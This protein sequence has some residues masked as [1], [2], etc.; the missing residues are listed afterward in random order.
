MKYK[1]LAVIAA[2]CMILNSCRD[3]TSFH[4]GWRKFSIDEHHRL[5][6]G[7]KHLHIPANQSG[8]FP[9]IY[10]RYGMCD[11]D[12]F[13][14]FHASDE[15]VQDFANKYN[16]QKSKP[17]DGAVQADPQSDI[18]EK[19]DSMYVPHED[20]DFFMFYKTIG[21]P[22]LNKLISSGNWIRYDETPAEY[23]SKNRERLLMITMIFDP[24][25]HIV[26]CKLLFQ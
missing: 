10:E 9:W 26:V 6:H 14:V 20:I 25:Q 8:D 24:T 17:K 12:A 18:R 15:W 21:D 5:L 7:V 13:L 23:T 11:Q 2:F 22:K 4:H 19:N 3:G 1:G 16:I